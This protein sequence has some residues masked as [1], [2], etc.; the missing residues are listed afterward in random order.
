MKC[1]SLIELFVLCS[2][3]HAYEGYPRVS[4]AIRSFTAFFCYRGMRIIAAVPPHVIQTS[5]FGTK[6]A[7]FPV[8]DDHAAKR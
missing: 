5:F 6:T 2:D 1:S 4:A 3:S 8:K 7:Q